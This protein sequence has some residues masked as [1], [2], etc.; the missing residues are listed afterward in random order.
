V[1]WR[2][3]VTRR[4]GAAVR[5]TPTVVRELSLRPVEQSL[6]QLAWRDESGGTVYDLQALAD[7]CR[8]LLEKLVA[9]GDPT[10][11][12]PPEAPRRRN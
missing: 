8:A 10:G 5:E 1:L 4:G 2:G 12:A 6:G 9:D 7:N 3:V 11:S